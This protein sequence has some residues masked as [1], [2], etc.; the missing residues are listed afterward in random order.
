MLR[1]LFYDGL[2]SALQLVS[3]QCLPR[4]AALDWMRWIAS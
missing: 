2:H 3:C 1:L 4:E